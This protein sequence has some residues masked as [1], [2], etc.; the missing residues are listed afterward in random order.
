VTINGRLPDAVA[1]RAGERVRLRLINAAA[2]RIMALRFVGHEP[3]IIALD[4][5]P[6]EPHAPE[7]GRVVLG[8]AM[9]TDVVID[10]TG[11]RGQRYAVMDDFYPDLAYRLVDLS[12]ADEPPIRTQPSEA[13]V[14]LP[15]NPVPEPD[16]ASAERY[17][18]VL[19]GGMP[20]M[21]GGGGMMGNGGGMMGMMSG[22]VW[23]MNGS[24]GN[25]DGMAPMLTLARGRSCVLELR[26]ETAW[27]H[28]MHLHGHSFRVLARNAQPTRFREWRDTV[29]I[30]PRE[31]A[32]IAFVAGDPGDWMIHC[33][34]LDHQE[35]GMMG[36]IRVA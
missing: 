6:V 10:M 36:V 26:N 2:A 31:T 15:P 18:I 3:L 22:A 4:G 33:H 20:G 13:I 9:R 1:V 19:G 25:G 21:M 27:W 28:P 35:S 23:T 34:V 17:P 7:G 12:Y 24:A 5:Q 14:R 29:L 8:P 30:P 16:L 11:R 32:E